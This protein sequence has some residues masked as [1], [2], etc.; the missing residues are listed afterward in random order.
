MEYPGRGEPLVNSPNVDKGI[1]ALAINIS[2]NSY[3]ENIE[4]KYHTFS[5][6]HY[7]QQI[8]QKAAD[9][10]IYI[11]ICILY[12]YIHIYILYI[13]IYSHKHTFYKK[14]YII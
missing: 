6:E 4:K 12:I 14:R 9:R 5:K 3:I 8:G 2:L 13:Y 7:K 10:V 11:C 1:T